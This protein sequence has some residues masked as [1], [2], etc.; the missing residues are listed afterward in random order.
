[1]WKY[2]LTKYLGTSFNFDLISNCCQFLMASIN[3]TKVLVG[4]I[5][6]LRIDRIKGR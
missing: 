4:I 2:L 5:R 6:Y 3:R 1:M